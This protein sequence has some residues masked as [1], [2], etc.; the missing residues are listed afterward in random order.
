[1]EIISFESE[2]NNTVFSYHIAPKITVNASFR[3]EE[4]M[5]VFEPV[6][7]LNFKEEQIALEGFRNNIS[8]RLRF[9][10][11]IDVTWNG[12]PIS[13]LRR[14]YLVVLFAIG[15]FA[16]IS[17]RSILM[18]VELRGIGGI[19]NRYS[20]QRLVNVVTVPQHTERKIIQMKSLQD[21]A[22]VAKVFQ[23]PILHDDNVFVVDHKDNRYQIRKT[24]DNDT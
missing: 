12:I 7:I 6:F 13:F 23:Q 20:T 4:I 17:V 18:Q 21:L 1:V 15:L 8:E 9:L 16:L 11:K 5:L 19:F 14:A 10:E 2:T 22:K 3:E 24:L